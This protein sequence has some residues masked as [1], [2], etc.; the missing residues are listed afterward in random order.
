MRRRDASRN[1]LPQRKKCIKT[2]QVAKLRRVSVR[3][4]AFSA[5]SVATAAVSLGQSVPLPD[6]SITLACD[7]LPA[8]QPPQRFPG[9]DQG[10]IE[11]K[12][13][14]QIGNGGIFL[15]SGLL[16]VAAVF[17]GQCINRVESL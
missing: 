13:L 4:P 17:V 11:K 7:E 16:E 6:A 1:G 12:G 9:T 2:A 8:S 15:A 5:D 14:P 10:R 3:A